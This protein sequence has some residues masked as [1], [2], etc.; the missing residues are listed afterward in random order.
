[1]FKNKVQRNLGKENKEMRVKNTGVERICNS[2]V[3]RLP[4]GREENEAKATHK[5]VMFIFPPTDK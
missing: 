5:E 4:K 1:M 2:C 3:N